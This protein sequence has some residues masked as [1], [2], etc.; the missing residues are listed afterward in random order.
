VEGL[1]IGW[2]QLRD[3]LRVEGALVP[4]SDNFCLVIHKAVQC[5]GVGPS[6]V[7]GVLA[8]KPVELETE[9]AIE[10]VPHLLRSMEGDLA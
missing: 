10:A 5:M 3:N 4:L 7:R 6:G 1:S 2:E 9:I 8:V